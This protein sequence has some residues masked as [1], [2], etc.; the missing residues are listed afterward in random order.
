MTGM[1]S[2]TEITDPLLWTYITVLPSGEGVCDICH[3]VPN[4]TYQTCYSC[5][6]SIRQVSHPCRLV[7]PISLSHWNTQLHHT[8]RSYKK[9]ELPEKTRDTFSLQ[10][11]ALFHRFLVAHK[12][13]IASQ[14]GGDWDTMTVVPSSQG[15]S[16][17]HPLELALRR[18][19]WIDQQMDVLLE[20]GDVQID[21]N[22]A[23]DAGFSPLKDVSGQKILLLDDTYTSGSRAQSAAS[24]LTKHGASVVAI[25]PAARYMNPDRELSSR[26]LQRAG[27][28]RYAFDYCCI[29]DH[30]LPPAIAAH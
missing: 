11:A 20:P 3:G 19:R 30:P 15:R 21:H 16:G 8:L 2:P 26:L 22:I 6:D 17:P 28:L 7:I 18:S 5:E 4:E 12:T 14:P 25:V 1:P 9:P 29:G 24:A 27:A 23:S 13:C 10:I